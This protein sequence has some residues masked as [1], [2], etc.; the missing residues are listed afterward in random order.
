MA[1]GGGDVP[2]DFELLGLHR[3]PGPTHERALPTEG[4]E[5]AALRPHAQRLGRGGRAG[6]DRGAGEL[7]ERGWERDGAVGARALY[8]WGGADWPDGRL[9]PTVIPE[10]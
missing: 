10:P 2:G 8:G 3:L 1:A 5:G 7:S 9:N 4:R 6:A